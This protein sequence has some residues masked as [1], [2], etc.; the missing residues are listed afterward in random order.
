FPTLAGTSTTK[1]QSIAVTVP[2]S[3]DVSVVPTGGSF[4]TT[5]TSQPLDF[6]TLTSGTSLGA[7]IL[8]RSNVSYSLALTSPNKG[9]MSNG[10]DTVPYILE[11]GTVT[12]SL[13]T[14]SAT[15]ATKAAKNNTA[16]PPQTKYAITATIGTL[17]ANLSSGTYTDTLTISLTAP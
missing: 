17:A 7:D 14:G 15:L 8:V 13:A 3:Y 1:T 16:V 9:V 10:V 2:N 11:L 6:G 5:T 4:S 12:K